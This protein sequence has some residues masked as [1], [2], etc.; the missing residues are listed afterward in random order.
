MAKR[1]KTI[2]SRTHESTPYEVLGIWETASFDEIRKAYLEKV[3]K[4]PPER[5][6]ENF[7]KIRNAYGLLK[8]AEKKR[9][10]DFT[11]FQRESGLK[12]EYG[13]HYDFTAMFKSRIFDILLESS[14]LYVRDFSKRFHDIDKEVEQ[15]Q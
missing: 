10:L 1:E 13:E 15:L 3:R 8:D 6:P 12:I 4:S 7:K 9:Q 11:L 14:D 2:P 5:D